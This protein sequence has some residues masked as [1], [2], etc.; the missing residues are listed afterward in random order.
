MPERDWTK[1]LSKIDKQLESVAD[2]ALFPTKSAKTP[3]AR[4]AAEEKQ[5]TTSTLGVM[6]RL[7]LSVGLGVAIWFW[8]YEAQC[9]LGLFGYLAAVGVVAMG[10]LWSAIWTWRHRSGRGHILSLLV[11]LWGMALAASQ[12]LPRVGY[13]KPDAAHPAGWMCP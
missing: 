2:E 10:G 7:L 9:G 3:A 8:P 12:V 5:R 11:I 13:G 4:A 1:E 6:I